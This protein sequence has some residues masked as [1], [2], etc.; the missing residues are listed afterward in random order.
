M[1]VHGL[2]IRVP[3]QVVDAR[4]RPR[5]PS[6][7]LAEVEPAERPARAQADLGI[8]MPESLAVADDLFDEPR[9]QRALI[10]ELAGAV[11]KNAQA[12]N[13]ADAG[14]V[15]GVPAVLPSLVK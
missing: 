15:N 4:Q 8:E 10:S 13:A 6:R 12:G 2:K 5:N 7:Q 14:I 9:R 1:R 11:G 3:R